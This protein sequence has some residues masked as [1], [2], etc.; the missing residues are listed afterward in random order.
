M[1]ALMMTILCTTAS[2]E[3]E[4]KIPLK[5]MT[6]NLRF[7]SADDGPDSWEYRK[8]ILVSVIR[9]QAPD[10]VGMQ[11]CLDFQADYI[12]QAL[13]QYRWLGI[14]RDG[15][16]KGERSAVLY[17]KNRFSPVVVRNRWLSETPD[18]PSGPAWDA[19][20]TRMVTMVQ[21]LDFSTGRYFFFCNTHF[22]HRGEMAREKSARLL[23]GWAT[24]MGKGMPVLIT[25]D[26][27]AAGESSIPWKIFS[28]QG[29]RDAWKIAEIREGPAGT[30]HAFKGGIRD[31]NYRIDWIL[32]NNRVKVLR[33]ATITASSNGH[34]PSDH[35]PVVAEVELAE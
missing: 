26:F 4:E 7:G 21:F 16:G 34:Y 27:N 33:C 20:C 32:V 24:Q 28:S 1:T 2:V 14:D 3:K 35:Y 29:Y 9:E 23:A 5:V 22:D 15:N 31:N 30:F 8:D 17:H 18:C 6:F 12:T 25:G 19:G 13:P 10:V 11:E